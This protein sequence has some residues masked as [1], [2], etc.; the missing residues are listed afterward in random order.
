M[1]ELSHQLK[2]G[3][4]S[5]ARVAVATG[6]GGPAIGGATLVVEIARATMTAMA[7]EEGTKAGNIASTAISAGSLITGKD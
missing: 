5:A 3:V 1:N 7:G 4:K 2:E 6:I